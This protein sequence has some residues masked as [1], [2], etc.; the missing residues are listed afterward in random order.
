MS[1]VK[2]HST[3]VARCQAR[4]SLTLHG[5]RALGDVSMDIKVKKHGTQCVFSLQGNLDIRTALDLK[6]ALDQSV[7]DGI[8]GVVV[9]LAGVTYIDSSG[10]AALI[11]SYNYAT[12]RHA[13]FCVA[14]TTP[15]IQTIFETAGMTTYLQILDFD[16][17]SR[18]Y[19]WAV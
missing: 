14:N 15:M 6:L 16:Q 5:V 4:N 9:D 1:S 3:S 10:L 13:D 7:T 17:F 19:P 11:K 2:I 8:S 12:E 18:R